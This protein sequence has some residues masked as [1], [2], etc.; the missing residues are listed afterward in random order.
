MKNAQ[1]IH[2]QVEEPFELNDYF[3]QLKSFRRVRDHIGIAIKEFS[4][5]AQILDENIKKQPRD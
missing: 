3:L 1:R 2:I 4:V 5:L